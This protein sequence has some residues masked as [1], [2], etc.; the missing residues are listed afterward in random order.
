MPKWEDKNEV[1]IGNIGEALV[2]EYFED[3]GWT[4]Y[5][6]KSRGPHLFDKI[7][8]FCKEELM[9]IEVKTKPHRKYYPDTGFNVKHYHEYKDISS[10]HNLEVFVSFVD[11]HISKVYGNYLKELEKPSLINNINYPLIIKS[12]IY[13]PLE[14]M[15]TLRVIPEEISKY[16]MDLSDRNYNY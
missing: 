1:I 4:I 13:F 6:T 16:I 15:F 12:I 11:P 10:K 2:K 5:I 8:M 3:R 14:N 7:A 9:I